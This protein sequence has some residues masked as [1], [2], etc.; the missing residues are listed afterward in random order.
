VWYF[1]WEH[2]RKRKIQKVVST[3]MLMFTYL[4]QAA[5]E[6]Q[7]VHCY[8][9]LLYWDL[10]TQEMPFFSFK[11]CFKF[12]FNLQLKCMSSNQF[13]ITMIIWSMFS[14]YKWQCFKVVNTLTRLNTHLIS[15]CEPKI[16]RICFVKKLISKKLALMDVPPCYWICIYRWGNKEPCEWR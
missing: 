12:K 1:F 14:T 3:N 4:L 7:N 10:L 16:S 6:N 2:V 13:F 11:Y 9:H 15:I 5:R 8:L